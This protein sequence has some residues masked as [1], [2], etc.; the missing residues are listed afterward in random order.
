MEID[1]MTKMWIS[2]LAIGLMVIASV[3]VTFARIKTKGAVRL[4][5]TIVAFVLLLLAIIYA[6]I[7]I[8]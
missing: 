5:L 7:S 3:L 2:F 4:L 6:M 1:S 8:L